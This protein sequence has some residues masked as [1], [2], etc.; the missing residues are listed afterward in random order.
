MERKQGQNDN[1]TERSKWKGNRKRVT[2][3]ER[4]E[5]REKENKRE[6]NEK[7]MKSYLTSI[8]WSKIHINKLIMC[9]A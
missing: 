2:N 4:E 1:R 9:N 6:R 8:S 3:K 5:I 7:N